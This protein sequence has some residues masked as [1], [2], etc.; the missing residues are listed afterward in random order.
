KM[1]QLGGGNPGCFRD[2]VD[3]RLRLPIAADVGDGAAHDVVIAGGA[4]ERGKIGNAI[5]RE[6]DGLHHLLPYLGREAFPAHPI[7][8]CRI[9]GTRARV[10]PRLAAPGA[11]ES[12]SANLS[13]SGG[14]RKPA[15]AGR[16]PCE[17]RNNRSMPNSACPRRS[18]RTHSGLSVHWLM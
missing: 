7:S 2:G 5:R 13:S 17:T 9:W 10:G 16:R 14:P 12:G 4:G 6:H 18:S 8:A 11:L 3:F 1:V 15:I